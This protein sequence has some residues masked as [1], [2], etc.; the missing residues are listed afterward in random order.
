M[1]RKANLVHA[2]NTTIY[3]IKEKLTPP[4]ALRPTSSQGMD[5]FRSF[6][7]LVSMNLEQRVLFDESGITALLPVDQAW[8]DLGLTEKYLLSASA[9]DSLKRVL[10]HCILKGVHYFD[11]FTEKQTKY[12]TIEGEEI[13]IRSQGNDH[14]VFDGQPHLK[15]KVDERDILSTNG[16]GHSLSIVPIPSTI[17][18]SPE[19]L[20]NA[21]GQTKWLSLL[22]RH[23]PE[24]LLLNSSHTLLIP[25]DAAIS[26]SSGT[27]PRL[28]ELLNFHII[29]PTS[30]GPVDLLAFPETAASTLSGQT[31]KIHK[32]YDNTY[33]INI[34]NT[35]GAFAR[36]LEQGKTSSGAQVLLIDGVLLGPPVG[37]WTIATL[38]AVGLTGV[39]VTVGIAGS[40]GWGIRVWQ[41]RRDGKVVDTEETDRL[42]DGEV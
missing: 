14:L 34:N 9:G 30:S 1:K 38:V 39:A 31:L 16:V 6:R 37:G 4:G 41:R 21:T 23:S 17:T 25:L 35:S 36:I 10:L 28:S 27:T 15:A 2:G 8:K 26:S 11:D 22:Q 32:I 19:N 42:L 33:T 12:T 13:E 20:I 18:I 40:V 24:Y 7:H 5:L 29:P 3:S